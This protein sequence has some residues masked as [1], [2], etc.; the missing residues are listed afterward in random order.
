MLVASLD[1]TPLNPPSDNVIAPPVH[2]D[3]GAPMILTGF[4]LTTNIET[5][6]QDPTV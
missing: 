4:E 3:A 5:A 2:T 1:H 6:A